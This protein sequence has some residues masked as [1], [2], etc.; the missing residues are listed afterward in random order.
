MLY[1]NKNTARRPHFTESW[2][3]QCGLLTVKCGREF[4][5]NIIPAFF[6]ELEFPRPNSLDTGWD[7][8]FHV[9]D[10]LDNVKK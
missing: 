4:T 2:N 8:N 9:R 5:P 7:G 6:G 1:F 10:F 3:I